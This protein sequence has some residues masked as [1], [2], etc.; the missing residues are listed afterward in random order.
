[1][2][3]KV[4]LPGRSWRGTSRRPKHEGKNQS[5]VFLHRAADNRRLEAAAYTTLGEGNNPT[6]GA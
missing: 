2:I 5:K 3:P 4:G 1:M 6:T